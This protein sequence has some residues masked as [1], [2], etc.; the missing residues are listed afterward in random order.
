MNDDLSGRRDPS[1]GHSKDMLLAF[2]R[3]VRA[4]RDDRRAVNA[5]LAEL[6][7]EI[8]AGGF[9]AAKVEAVVR[10]QEDCEDKGRAVVDEAEALFDLYRSVADGGGKDFDE[11]M[12]DARDRALLKI[13]APED[14]SAP[15]APTRKQ[16]AL[17]DA[18]AAAQCNRMM[19]E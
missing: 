8:R 19:R 4:L 9:D 15:K 6:R 11:M 3:R 16:R 2:L 12:D 10:W 7:K 13:F 5:D 17:S 14:Q 1:S 18:I